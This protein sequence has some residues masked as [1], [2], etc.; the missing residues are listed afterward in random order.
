M[1]QLKMKIGILPNQYL[2]TDGTFNKKEAI[3]LSGKIAGV[4]YDKDGFENL[5]NE[6]VQIKNLSKVFFYVIISM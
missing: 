4:C 1:E 2:K 5:L 6:F 3:N